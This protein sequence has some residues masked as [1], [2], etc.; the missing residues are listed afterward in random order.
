MHEELVATLH[1]KVDD[2]QER[3][4]RMSSQMEDIMQAFNQFEEFSKRRGCQRKG[5]YATEKLVRTVVNEIRAKG[6][7]YS[8]RIHY[9]HCEHCQKY[10]L[11]KRI[12]E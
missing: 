3:I 7:R 9:Y 10:H 11:T 4:A 8:K 5:S 6:G 1:R 2:M 12:E